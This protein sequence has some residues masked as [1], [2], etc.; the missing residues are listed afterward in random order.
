M[1]ILYKTNPFWI[2]KE[3]KRKIKNRKTSAK[4]KKYFKSLGWI[5]RYDR[6]GIGIFYEPPRKAGE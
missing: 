6:K 1:N 2:Y 5:P 4:I 3:I